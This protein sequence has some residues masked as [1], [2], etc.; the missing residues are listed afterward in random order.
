MKSKR[1]TAFLLSAVMTISLLPIFSLTAFAEALEPLKDSTTNV[2]LSDADN[3]GM[4]DIGTKADLIAFSNLVNAGN[5]TINAELTADI[6]FNSKEVMSRFTVTD[7]K[8]TP[9]SGAEA[10][11]PIGKSSMLHLDTTTE[12]GLSYR[13]T[14]DGNNHTISGMFV[15]K[16]ANAD[17]SAEDGTYARGLFG[18][19]GPE[20]IVKNL[21]VKDSC[22]YGICLTGGIVGCLIDGTIENCK[23]IDGTLF[24]T[25][26]A[27]RGREM[28]VG[29]IVG[30][31][32]KCRTPWECGSV[33]VVYSQI[34]SCS[35]S[36]VIF[37][38]NGRGW[39]GIVG[40]TSGN[41][42]N[43]LYD[44]RTKI[45]GCTAN[46]NLSHTGA[47][48]LVGGIVGRAVQCCIENC[49][50]EGDIIQAGSDTG[51]YIGGIAGVHEIGVMS[52]CINKGNITCEGKEY[53]VG[54]LVGLTRGMANEYQKY[55]LN[56]C[57]NI[58]SVTTGGD[59]VGGLVGANYQTDTQNY[60]VIYSNSYNSAVVK[61]GDYVGGI[62]GQILG[63]SA[64]TSINMCYSSGKITAATDAANVGGI[65]GRQNISTQTSTN[66]YDTD[67]YSGPAV[68]I[69]QK[70]T[71][72]K[73]N[74]G[75]STEVFKSG[76]VAY[77]L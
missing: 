5:T 4:Y 70:D 53:Y 23:Y 1:I 61:G 47:M 64:I 55:L 68:G 45:K 54:G 77:V 57:Y 29:G 49:V 14:F 30:L 17:G 73:T 51:N 41:M 8:I 65:T 27:Q 38:G 58:G 43:S 66:Y 52:S 13:G 39:G 74:K 62:S 67:K 16:L 2:T 44:L 37:A 36:N 63:K 71:A 19:V 69:S 59:Y 10:F 9:A 7:S 24:S 21:T 48:A 32:T 35:S 34:I 60:H 31:A 3:N 72:A 12:P 75:V 76:E 28:G 26:N 15:D 22:I 33:P 50:N 25:A 40:A 42:L 46:N 56:K 11:A 18:Y 6:T 20:G